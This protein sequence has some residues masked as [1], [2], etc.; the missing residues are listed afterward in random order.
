MLF[1]HSPSIARGNGHMT[2][3]TGFTCASLG[4]LLVNAGFPVVLA[5]R[6]AFDLWVL[7]LMEKADQATLQWQLKAAGLDFYSEDAP[8]DLATSRKDA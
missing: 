5:Q 8:A 6:S 2:H 3:R 4:R 1:G 7:A